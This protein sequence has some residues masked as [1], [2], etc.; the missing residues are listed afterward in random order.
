MGHSDPLLHL[1]QPQASKRHP[2]L[3]RFPLELFPTY[4]HRSHFS[5]YGPAVQ[6][7]R[8]DI[9]TV[10]K[11]K[12]PSPP[13]QISLVFRIGDRFWCG[14]AEFAWNGVFVNVQLKH[15]DVKI[16]VI[17]RYTGDLTS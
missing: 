15:Y 12:L 11:S 3:L 14:A 1:L 8:L 13:L 17:Q 9:Q 4:L 2:R 5:I 10:W 6:M 7:E 16:I